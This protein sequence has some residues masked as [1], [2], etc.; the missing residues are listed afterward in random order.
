MGISAVGTQ[1]RLSFRAER[2]RLW[3]VLLIL[4]AVSL[5]AAIPIGWMPNPTGAPGAPFVV[6]TSE[7][8][9][10]VKPAENGQ[11]ARRQSAGSHED[12]VFG[13]VAATTT[14][15]PILPVAPASFAAAARLAGP[16]ES[17][18]NPPRRHRDQ[19]Q[20]APPQAI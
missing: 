13:W 10:L 3:S 6:C 18:T 8:G 5:R 7:G 2:S 17:P 15:E 19:A 16:A 9:R 4:A 12:C 20:R 11:P 14:H 1:P